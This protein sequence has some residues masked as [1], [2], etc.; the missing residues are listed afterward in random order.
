MRT[1]TAFVCIRVWAL[2]PGVEEPEPEGAGPGVQV[3][4]R[5]L[6]LARHGTVAPFNGLWRPASASATDGCEAQTQAKRDSLA[7]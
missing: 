3:E 6:C 5:G 7:G 2:L 1:R 4:E